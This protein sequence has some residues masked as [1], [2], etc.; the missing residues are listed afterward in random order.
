MVMTEIQSH[1]AGIELAQATAEGEAFDVL[2]SE[3]TFVSRRNFTT[4]QLE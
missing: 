2:N 3:T 4:D 1:S